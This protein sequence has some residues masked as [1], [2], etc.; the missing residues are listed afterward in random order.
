M[1]GFKQWIKLFLSVALYC[2]SP[3]AQAVND[4]SARLSYALGY[5]FSTDLAQ[6][7]LDVN[8][9]ALVS[10]IMDSFGET[11]Q[12]SDE[13]IRQALIALEHKMVALNNSR[14][15]KTEQYRLKNEAYLRDN[16]TREQVTTTES[17]LQYEIIRQGEGIPPRQND[18]VTVHYKGQLINDWVFDSSYRRNEPLSI[19]VSD[20]IEG[21]SEALQAM[22][23]GAHWRLYIPPHLAYGGEVMAG[24]IPA[25][26]TLIFD[27]ELLSVN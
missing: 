14:E 21:W 6:Q 17:G 24:S 16:A 23:P 7:S 26:S 4:D 13:E 22:K 27:V 5:Q 10:G 25:N 9:E 8:V 12:L 18:S 15:S 2:L 1:F 19:K 20:V 3:I 11:S